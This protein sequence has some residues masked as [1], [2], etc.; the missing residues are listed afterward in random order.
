MRPP[1]T[2]SPRLS[3]MRDLGEDHLPLLRRPRRA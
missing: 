1:M 2:A 3:A